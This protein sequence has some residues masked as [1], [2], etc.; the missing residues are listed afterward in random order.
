MGVCP[1][2]ERRGANTLKLKAPNWSSGPA[3]RDDDGQRR[4]N[5]PSLRESNV[6]V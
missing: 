3:H 1:I 6:A 4:L 5:R 2:L